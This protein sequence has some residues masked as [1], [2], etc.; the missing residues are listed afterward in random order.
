M[1]SGKKKRTKVNRVNVPTARTHPRLTDLVR[2]GVRR[3]RRPKATA[4]TNVSH[5]LEK[6]R[7]KKVKDTQDVES[8]NMAMTGGARGGG[9]LMVV[10]EVNVTS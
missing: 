4:N 8:R 5:V 7:G 1:P 9:G 2:P 6:G 3:R 10:A